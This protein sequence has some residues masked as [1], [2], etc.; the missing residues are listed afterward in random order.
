M[1]RFVVDS[2]VVKL[3]V[4]LVDYLSLGTICDVMIPKLCTIYNNCTLNV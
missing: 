4:Y 1:C 3:K 2:V